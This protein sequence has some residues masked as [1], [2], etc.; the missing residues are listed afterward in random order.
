MQLGYWDRLIHLDNYLYGILLEQAL[1][2]SLAFQ[3]ILY[4]Y[5]TN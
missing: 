1:L 3:Q 4:Q 5:A 2:V